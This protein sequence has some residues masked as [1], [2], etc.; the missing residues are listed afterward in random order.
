MKRII[1]ASLS[2]L[3]ICLTSCDDDDDD[4]DT[5][6][7]IVAI[8]EANIEGDELCVQA[9]VTAD[10]ATAEITLDVVS[11]DGK[12]TKVSKTVSD[13]K[14][15]GV[16]NIPGFHVHV[17]IADKGVAVGDLLKMTIKDNNG[18]QTTAQKDITEE[19]EDED[20]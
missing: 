4:D 5:P 10:G 1:F 13:S 18:K 11:Q 9:N 17:Q 7:P 2:L 20:E 14:Y 12:T 19:E 8:T 15:I 16:L 6:A 3:S